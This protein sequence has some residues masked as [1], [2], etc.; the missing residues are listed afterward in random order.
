M[1]VMW[2]EQV[3]LLDKAM[4]DEISFGLYVPTLGFIC[5][6]VLILIG[7]ML[8]MCIPLHAMLRSCKSSSMKD[9]A[10]PRMNGVSKPIPEHSPLLLAKNSNKIIEMQKFG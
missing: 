1:P 7:I 4:A 9:N 3:V 2:F 5:C 10:K 8:I 6:G